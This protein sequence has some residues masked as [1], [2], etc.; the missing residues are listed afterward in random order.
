MVKR[1]ILDHRGVFTAELWQISIVLKNLARRF[2]FFVNFLIALFPFDHGLMIS[3][4]SSA[5]NAIKTTRYT[6]LQMKGW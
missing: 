3:P 6:A 5:R 2:Y 1:R 4:W